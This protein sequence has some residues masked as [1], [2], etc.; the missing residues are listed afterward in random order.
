MIEFER[1]SSETLEKYS[2]LISRCPYNVNDISVGSFYMWNE[3]VCLAFCEAFGSF[4]SVQDIC[5]E[6]SFSYPFG[7]DDEKA[8]DALIEY[9]REKD[10]PLKFY[11]VTDEL[12]EKL[13]NS[14]RFPKMMFNYDRKWSDYVYD[15]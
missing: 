3:G 9:V 11:G 1:Y 13:R 15:A 4:I 6:P 10:L 7:G 8:T 2:P 5:E 12:L 14:G